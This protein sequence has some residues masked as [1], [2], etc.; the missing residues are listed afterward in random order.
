ML[1][2]Y[3][4][5]TLWSGS[6]VK[7]AI[8]AAKQYVGHISF[9]AGAV[10]CYTLFVS[11]NAAML[12]GIIFLFAYRADSLSYRILFFALVAFFIGLDGYIFHQ[13]FK[14][15]MQRDVLDTAISSIAGGNTHYKIET[16]RL[17]GKEK[18]MESISIISAADWIR[19][20]CSRLK[21][22]A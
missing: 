9:A 20:L 11:A 15:A 8:D 2:R 14:K 3:K 7:K 17:S 18:D 5:R 21:A 16:V 13:M 19:P 12:W 4:A 1:R 10:F 22:N 6:L